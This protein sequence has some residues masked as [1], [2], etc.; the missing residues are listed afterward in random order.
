MP[1]VE[2][3]PPE[4]Q[5]TTWRLD[6]AYEGTAYRGWAKQPGHVSVEGLLE[7]ALVTVLR[8]PVRLSVAGRTDAGVHAWAQVVSFTCARGDLAPE[9]LRLSLN[10]LLPPDIAVLRA[11][12]APAGLVVKK[13]SNA[14][15][16]TSGGMP[17]PVSLTASR[18]NWPGFTSAPE[19]RT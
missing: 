1:G 2:E 15:S 16:R 13:G 19:R 12:P 11:E 8:E 14:L 17:S 9:R 6:V 7:G 18:T 10:A 4:Q 3:K 5:P